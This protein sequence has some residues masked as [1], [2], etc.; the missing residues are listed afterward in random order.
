[1]TCSFLIPNSSSRGG[2]F[3]RST[4]PCPYLNANFDCPCIQSAR[5]FEASILSDTYKEIRRKTVAAA[6]K[7]VVVT[8]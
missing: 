3:C 4:S 7:D 5:E 8:R 6:C 1:M 2:Y